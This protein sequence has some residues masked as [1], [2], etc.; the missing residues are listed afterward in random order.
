MTLRGVPHRSGTQRSG[1]I[2]IAA[3]LETKE[4]G[5]SPHWTDYLLAQQ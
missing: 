4:Q 5:A 2:L 1:I 3:I